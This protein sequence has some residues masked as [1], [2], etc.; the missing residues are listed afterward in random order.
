MRKGKGV[1][2]YDAVP[3]LCGMAGRFTARDL[4]DELGCSDRSARRII[5]QLCTDGIVL[6]L[7]VAGTQPVYRS[8]ITWRGYR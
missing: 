4:A 8:A 7:C 1:L 2:R 6:D 5:A 3:W